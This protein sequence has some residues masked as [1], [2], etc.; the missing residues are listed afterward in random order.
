MRIKNHTHSWLCVILCACVI[1]CALAHACS[2]MAT[3][4]AKYYTI[5]YAGILGSNIII[6]IEVQLG[7]KLRRSANYFVEMKEQKHQNEIVS[8]KVVVV[9]VLHGTPHVVPRKSSAN[10]LHTTNVEK[11]SEWKRYCM[12]FA[13]FQFAM[14]FFKL[15]QKCN[16]FTASSSFGIGAFV[17]Y[18]NVNI[19]I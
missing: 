3:F 16:I 18:F 9:L 4:I 6:V 12:V 10:P 5:L 15:Q 13:H 2:H 7:R 14:K 17:R 8:T 19:K 1:I 11:R